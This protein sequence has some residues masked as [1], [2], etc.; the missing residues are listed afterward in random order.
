M[1]KA[2]MLLVR[3]SSK[4]GSKF[5]QRD[6]ITVQRDAEITEEGTGLS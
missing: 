1:S 5:V 3:T 6:S 2:K 4:C